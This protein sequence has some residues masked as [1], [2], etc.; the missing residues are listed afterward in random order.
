MARI[1]YTQEEKKQKRKETYLRYRAKN[2]E[3]ILERER[4]YRENNT[5]ARK[6]SQKKYL[7][8]NQERAKEN[9]QI[10]TRLNIDKIKEQNRLNSIK[11][12]SIINARRKNRRLT[13][14]VYRDKCN[15]WGRLNK[16]KRAFTASKRRSKL[17]NA[18]PNWLSIQDWNDIKRF[19]K[20]C[21]FLTKK[22]GI[23]Y[24][25]DHIHPLQGIEVCGLHVPWNLQILTD[26]DN[27]SKGN[28]LLPEYVNS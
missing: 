11:N 9:R 25:V 4:I 3:K 22:T 12:R 19:Y 1:K 23:K 13:D 17:L 6:A 21:N 10:W 24:T 26:S 2:R 15:E 27:T 7:E 18:T 20:V 28:K 5:E 16:D 8:N 14:P